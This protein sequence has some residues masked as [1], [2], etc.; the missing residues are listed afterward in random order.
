MEA[1]A[2][3]GM[4]ASVQMDFMGLTVKKVIDK[5]PSR[6]GCIYLFCKASQAVPGFQ[7]MGFSR[8]S[9]VGRVLPAIK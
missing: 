4:S 9:D 3:N 1:F 6:T 5:L 7:N 8:L 2:M